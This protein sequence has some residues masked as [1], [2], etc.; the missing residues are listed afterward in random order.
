MLRCV[1]PH[2][3]L[4]LTDILPPSPLLGDPTGRQGGGRG[5]GGRAGG[6]SIRGV[7]VGGAARVASWSPGLSRVWSSNCAAGQ[8][9][10]AF[11][12]HERMILPRCSATTTVFG[13]MPNPRRCGAAPLRPSFAFLIA[14]QLFRTPYVTLKSAVFDEAS[15]DEDVDHT[16]DQDFVP[17]DEDTAKPKS[18][19]PRVT[20]R[21][22]AVAHGGV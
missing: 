5:E 16:S 12:E 1:P 17:S 20:R 14:P 6:T 7:S 10:S 15:S 13:L 4:S 19:S 9:F 3:Y 11:I 18:L 8:T 21:R 22:A 2:V